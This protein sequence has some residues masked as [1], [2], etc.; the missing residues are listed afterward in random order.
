MKT[1]IAKLK[2]TNTELTDDCF[3]LNKQRLKL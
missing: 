1:D 3:L 2:E